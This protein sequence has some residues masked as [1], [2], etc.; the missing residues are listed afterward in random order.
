MCGV[1]SVH[2]VVRQ[3]IGRCAF[4]QSKTQWGV[5]VAAF[6]SGG[7]RNMSWAGACLLEYTRG[8]V[9]GI[10]LDLHSRIFDAILMHG[11]SGLRF[12]HAS[13]H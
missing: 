3:G 13:L 12:A 11:A 6:A 4:V 10:G 9:G 7:C 5:G 1:L 8:M 2:V